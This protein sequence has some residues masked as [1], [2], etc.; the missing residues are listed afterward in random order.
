MLMSEKRGNA[1]RVTYEEVKL[2][3]KDQA[4]LGRLTPPAGREKE[5]GRELHAP[6]RPDNAQ[7]QFNS[8]DRDLFMHLENLQTFKNTCV[9]TGTAL[10]RRAVNPQFNGHFISQHQIYCDVFARTHFWHWST[11]QPGTSVS[12]RL[13]SWQSSSLN[14]QAP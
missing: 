2:L 9:L 3:G 8:R 7:S 11:V 10:E 5:R 1:P 6:L 12:T 13:K 4:Q 14:Q